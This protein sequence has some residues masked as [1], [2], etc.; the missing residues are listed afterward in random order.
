MAAAGNDYWVDDYWGQ[1]A[2][3][4][5]P[6]Q[7]PE[8]WRG[9]PLLFEGPIL[10]DGEP[11][12]V[13][14]GPWRLVKARGMRTYDDQPYQ[15]TMCPQC[16]SFGA[17]FW[18]YAERLAC[19]CLDGS[20]DRKVEGGSD[21]RLLA[22]YWAMDAEDLHPPRGLGEST[23]LLP[24]ARE[25]LVDQSSAGDCQCGSPPA[26]LG[27]AC[28]VC[29]PVVLMSEGQARQQLNWRV[30][31]LAAATGQ[32]GRTVNALVN[33]SIG[34]RSRTGIALAQLGAALTQAEQWLEDPSSMP[35]ARPSVS[36]EDLD[37]L[38]GRELRERLTTYVGPLSSALR[39]P[40]PFVQ[41]RLNDWMGVTARAEATDD[42]LRDAIMQAAAWL[43]NTDAYYAYVTPQPVEPGGLPAPVHTKQAPADSS[44][45]LCAAP[46][47]AGELIGR[48]PRPR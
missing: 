27:S 28:R 30:E 40:I 18:G 48:M 22:A 29:Q 20:K 15:W 8:D 9:L 25:V 19:A 39:E 4:C 2:G 5:L 45:H 14:N 32:H 42:L 1:E 11:G 21:K 44:C 17:T 41:Q 10:P 23:L 12:D 38:H 31:Q 34:V 43:T 3:R 7:V 13:A 47:A 26:A 6:V 37:K 36:Y 35:A 16:G 33:K 24:T 46:V